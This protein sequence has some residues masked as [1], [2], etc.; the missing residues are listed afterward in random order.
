M[1]INN[2]KLLFIHI[3]KCGGS[4][5]SLLLNKYRVESHY[6]HCGHSNYV[7]Y[8]NRIGR[9][10]DNYK[11]FTIVRNPWAWHVSWFHYLKGIEPRMHGHHIEHKLFNGKDFD[12]NNYID[13]LIDEK[14]QK[15][16]QNFII[17]NQYDWCIN[18]DGV[19]KVDH[20][21]R[22]ENLT[23]D[24][25]EFCEKYDIVD[26]TLLKINAS[27]HNHYK[28]YYEPETIKIIADRHEKDLTKFN[29]VY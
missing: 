13:W 18:N 6:K 22:L 2:N 19:F 3:P 9:D 7:E 26:D 21:L 24:F 1:I 10:I 20:I 15:S 17:R 16:S 8:E 27:K 28:S 11:I 25:N 14:Q 5:L 29:Y 12:F 4:S 23:H